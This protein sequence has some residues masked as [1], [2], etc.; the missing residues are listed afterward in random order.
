MKQRVKIG[1]FSMYIQKVAEKKQ[2]SR[3][4]EDIYIP[5]GPLEYEICLW[6]VHEFE[7]SK[8]HN[9]TKHA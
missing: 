8:L 4:D 5:I 7:S 6:I 9:P 3:N 2:L 1:Q